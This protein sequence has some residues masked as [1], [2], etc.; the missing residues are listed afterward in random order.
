M[1][2][3][4]QLEI[5]SQEP[6]HHG[7]AAT[8]AEHDLDMLLRDEEEERQCRREE[9]E[10]DER[11]AKFENMADQEA[12]HLQEQAAEFRA[13]EERQMAAAM[14]KGASSPPHKKRCVLTLEAASSSS[15]R[16]RIMHTIELEVP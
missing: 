10:E 13:W 7:G 8:E 15:D 12:A 11:V 4:A 5:E 9:E 14:E 2:P 1:L 3:S 6:G 16:P